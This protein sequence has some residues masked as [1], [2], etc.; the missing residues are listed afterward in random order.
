MM[1]IE[2]FFYG[3]HPK[4]RKKAKRDAAYGEHEFVSHC[5]EVYRNT[6]I[7]TRYI[8][9]RIYGGKAFEVCVTVKERKQ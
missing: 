7:G 2:K 3:T 4:G 9:T 8:G 5:V 1:G 6:G